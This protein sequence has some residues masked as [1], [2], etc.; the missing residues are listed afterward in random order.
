M[1]L[2]LLEPLAEGG[3]DV[4]ELGAVLLG[5]ALG[6]LAP[7]QQLVLGLGQAVG[8]E[9]VM[10]PK[11]VRTRWAGLRSAKRRRL[12]TARSRS[13]SGGGV[14]GRSTPVEGSR[15]PTPVPGEQRP[16]SGSNTARWCLAWPGA[17]SSSR[18]RPPRS[19]TSPS[20]AALIRAAS[21][22][23]SPP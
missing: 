14:A 13:K 12:A 19:R 8:E 21:T 9:G 5:G 11:W 18:R 7:A 15:T 2:L 20:S 6:G 3:L 22:G 1:A 23:V 16:R 4:V 10:G 17:C